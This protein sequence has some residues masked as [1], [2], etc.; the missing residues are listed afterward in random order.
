METELFSVDYSDLDR[1]VET[2]FPTEKIPRFS[3]II[4]GL[5]DGEIPF[6]ELFS[7]LKE[8]GYHGLFYGIAGVKELIFIAVVST[9]KTFVTSSSVNVGSFS[10]CSFF[11][12]MFSNYYHDIFSFFVVCSMLDDFH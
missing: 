10:I 7:L 3:D 8:S 12:R 9:T 2:L 1:T 11:I 4:C 6:D 5:M